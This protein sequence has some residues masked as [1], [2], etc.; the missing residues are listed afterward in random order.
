MSV[1]KNPSDFYILAIRNQ[2]YLKKKQYH[3][4]R[5]KILVFESKLRFMLINKLKK[6]CS[7]SLL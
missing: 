1:G 5:F 4:N 6:A 7:D 3:F 2:K